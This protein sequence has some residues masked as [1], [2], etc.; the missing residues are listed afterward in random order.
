MPPSRPRK[1]MVNEAQEI[2]DAI[3]ASGARGEG[4]ALLNGE[5]I[6]PPMELRA[7]KIMANWNKI[8][9]NEGHDN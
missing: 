3:E 8:I 4:V 2:I 9:G 1:M 6:G 5:L 7:R